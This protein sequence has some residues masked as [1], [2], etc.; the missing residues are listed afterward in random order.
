[1]GRSPD[2][3]TAGLI[4]RQSR[5]TIQGVYEFNYER[6]IGIKSKRQLKVTIQ[7]VH[8]RILLVNT[9]VGNSRE[10]SRSRRGVL[11]S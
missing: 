4:P 9:A 11:L 2:L 6:E 1:V 10:V 5:V 3:A 8:E 7:G